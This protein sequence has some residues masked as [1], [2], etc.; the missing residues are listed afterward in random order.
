MPL[1]AEELSRFFDRHRKDW[2]HGWNLLVDRGHMSAATREQNLVRADEIGA[3]LRALAE[4]QA[5][6]VYQPPE[7]REP[8]PMIWLPRAV[9]SDA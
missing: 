4:G 1:H 8:S 3:I 2:E 5:V 9:G 7:Q 6:L